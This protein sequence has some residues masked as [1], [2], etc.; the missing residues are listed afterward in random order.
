MRRIERIDAA[1]LPGPLP[2]SRLI[3]PSR[4][5]LSDLRLAQIGVTV[6]AGYYLGA[7][8]GLALTFLPNPISVL[9][10]P[11]AILFAALLLVPP[12]VWWVVIAAALPAHLFAELQDG[13]P[14][15]MVMCWFVSN[16]TEAAIGASI[17]RALVRRPFTFEVPR[18]VII[19]LVA[20]ILAA[21]LS[22]FLD[23]AFVKLNGWGQGDYWDVW[24]TRTW[25]N[26]TA[27]LII[28]PT[29]VTWAHTDL[30]RANSAERSDLLEAAVLAMGLLAATIFVFDTRAATGYSSAQLAES[31]WVHASLA[32]SLARTTFP[33]LR[34]ALASDP[35]A[36]P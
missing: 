26:V 29:I 34:S 14:V 32:S 5:G 12:N 33:R 3:S 22:S 19:F 8:L 35:Q 11:N 17:V 31:P 4:V 18:K 20:A 16:V 13:I 15:S 10:P 21:L 1:R 24:S 9:W 27:S 2:G 25:S 36:A 23:T 7:K 30:A 28:V 6:F